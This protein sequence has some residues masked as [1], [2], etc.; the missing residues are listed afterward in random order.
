VVIQFILSSPTHIHPD[1]IFLTRLVLTELILVHLTEIKRI[2]TEK[3]V[4]Y[5]ALHLSRSSRKLSAEQISPTLPLSSNAFAQCLSSRTA[6]NMLGVAKIMAMP[7][8]LNRNNLLVPKNS[9]AAM[10]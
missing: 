7:K 3:I 2:L 9:R 4:Q 8:Y 5:V 6:A 1:L 10:S